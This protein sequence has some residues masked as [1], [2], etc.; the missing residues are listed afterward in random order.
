MTAKLLVV[1][2]NPDN[3]KLFRWTL[4]EEGYEVV[5]VETGEEALETISPEFDLVIMDISLPG[6]DGKEATQRIRANETVRDVPI[7]ACTAHAIKDEEQAI[8]AS[9]VDQLVTKPI[10]EDEFVK[11]IANALE[12]KP[13]CPRS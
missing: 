10:D 3:R 13:T 11:V 2:D 5:E 4:E 6:I 12:E 7:I 1:E 8:W 9:G